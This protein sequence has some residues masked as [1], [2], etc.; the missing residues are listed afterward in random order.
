MWHPQKIIGRLV[1]LCVIFALAG[2]ATPAQPATLTASLPNPTLSETENPMGLKISQIQ[3]A[4][5]RS[6]MDGQTVEN[7]YGIVTAIKGDGFYLQ[8]PKP[9][10]DPR[11]S[12]AIFTAISAYRK[13]AVGDEVAIYNGI[14]REYNPAGIGENSLTITQ[15]QTSDYEVITSDNPL[16]EPMVLGADGR[17]IPNQII[18][19][20]VNG[21]AGRDGIFDPEE[22]GMDFFE[23]VESMRVQ[24]N[25]AIAVSA[26]SAYKEVV[27]V[28]DGAEDASVLSERGVLVLQE[29]DSNPE[30]IMLDDAFIT[31]PDIL[32]GA[33]FTTPIIGIMDY[34]FGNF[35][36]QP[37]TKLKFIQGAQ[38]FDAISFEPNSSQISIATYNVENLDALDNPSK[39]TVLAHDIIKVLR[40][41]DI[42]ALQEIQDNDG[43][44]DSSVTAADQTLAGILNAI[45]LAGGPEYRALSIDPERNA[46]GG[47]LGRNIRVAL[48]YRTDRGLTK[49]EGSSGDA[50]SAVVVQNIGG[51]PVL[52]LN[53][54]RISPMSHAFMDSRKPLVAQFRFKN[55]DLFVIVN[56]LNSKGEDGPLYGDI[57]PPPLNSELQRVEQTVQIN[58]FVDGLLSFAPLANVV[59][60]GDLND[61]PW[62]EPV[63][64]LC[65]DVLVNLVEQLPPNERYTYIHE[66]NGQVL[67][68]ILVSEALSDRVDYFNIAHVNSEQLYDARLSDHDPVLAV[69]GFE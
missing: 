62:S 65:G 16:P 42:I 37:T 61:F 54:G 39:L 34:T 30:R 63:K 2:C 46:D 57:Q 22:N 49:V 12:E 55:Q 4:Q 25:N 29:D 10:D 15:I 50:D 68:Q 31:M 24:V 28:A 51:K 67:D 23:S 53:P 66:G 38:P 1:S 48:L 43:L 33:E 40:T 44:L 52:S 19:N 69:F 59:V 5:H 7:V 6:P 47:A 32:V 41:P 14:V 64:T 56:H 21:Y 26:T 3:G 45:R 18:K 9:D 13:V 60:L 58:T 11:T 8:D 36:L 35:K 17:A 20:D 27:I